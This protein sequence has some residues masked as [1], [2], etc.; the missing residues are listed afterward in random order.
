MRERP[1]LLG[2]M[3]PICGDANRLLLAV[4][5]CVRSFPRHPKYQVRAELRH[6]DMQVARLAQR[7]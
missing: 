2:G 7:V 5:Q 4:D 6:Q 1:V 3:P